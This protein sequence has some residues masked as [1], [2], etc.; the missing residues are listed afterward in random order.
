MTCLL[1]YALLFPQGLLP[2]HYDLAVVQSE[3]FAAS[4]GW[5]GRVLF[6]VVAAAFLS[7]A[8]LATVGAVARP[9]TDCVYGFFSSARSLSARSW[10]LIFLCALTLVSLSTIL[11]HERGPLIL[12]SAV[13]GFVGLS[14]V[15]YAALAT[16]YFI[17]NRAQLR[18]LLFLAPRFVNLTAVN[19]CVRLPLK[20]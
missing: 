4:C 6:L 13:I 5:P 17:I 20:D 11:F 1:A 12:R 2:D 18:S 15:V 19:G 10:Y 8:W 3:F 14:C 7:N 16:A 9:H